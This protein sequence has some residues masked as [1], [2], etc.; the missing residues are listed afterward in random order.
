MFINMGKLT[1]QLQ[2]L[3][4]EAQRIIV[5]LEGANGAVHLTVNGLQQ[6]LEVGFGPGAPA[7]MAQGR[8][9]PVIRDALNQALAEARRQL[10]EE[11]TKKTGITLPHLPGLF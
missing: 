6:V 2:E 5:P 11:V 9:G 3:H 8:L 10:K 7:L 1:Q 4:E